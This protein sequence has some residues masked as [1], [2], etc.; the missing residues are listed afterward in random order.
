MDLR[1]MIGILVILI[2]GILSTG[3]CLDNSSS[4]NYTTHDWDPANLTESKQYSERTRISAKTP[5]ISSTIIRSRM[6]MSTS[7]I[8]PTPPAS[9]NTAQAPYPQQSFHYKRSTTHG[10]GKA[11][12]PQLRN[13][14][15]LN[16][17]KLLKIKN[18]GLTK[19]LI[20]FFCNMSQ[21]IQKLG[22]RE[23]WRH[24]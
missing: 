14:W 19:M 6:E 7:S 11:S 23:S 1:N 16:E 21:T 12:K 4:S 18:F 20:K 5:S 8:S 2:V 13:K 9:Q 10:Q 15:A 17:L 24:L 3:L 22:S